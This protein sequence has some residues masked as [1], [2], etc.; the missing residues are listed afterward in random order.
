M[1]YSKQYIRDVQAGINYQRLLKS[2]GIEDIADQ[3]MVP[4]EHIHRCIK[5]ARE[6]KEASERKPEV[7]VKEPKVKL[8][9]DMRTGERQIVKRIEIELMKEIVVNHGYD[10]VHEFTAVMPIKVTV[11]R[12]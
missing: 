8:H 4:E 11:R 2:M 5:I 10:E 1:T 3:M 7:E 12:A 9:F 6:H